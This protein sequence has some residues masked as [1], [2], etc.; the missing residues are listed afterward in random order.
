L[1]NRNL[2]IDYTV[3]RD[4][5]DLL[6]D[7]RNDKIGSKAPDRNVGNHGNNLGQFSGEKI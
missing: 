7:V 5:S 1:A 3:P 6:R 2:L 4:L